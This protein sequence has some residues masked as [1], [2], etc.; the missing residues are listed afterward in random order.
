VTADFVIPL[1]R[2]FFEK[3]K[4]S[5]RKRRLG[6]K[7]LHGQ[8]HDMRVRYFGV[9]L[10][11]NLDDE[12]GYEIAINRFEWRELKMLI[13]ACI[14][15]K[16]DVFIDAGANLGLYSCV[17]GHLGLVPR[18]IAFEPDRENFARLKA[19]LALN[20]L[21]DRVE[22]HEAALG[23]RFGTAM[24]VPSASDN[25]GMSR[26]GAA[27]ADG[28]YEVPVLALDEAVPHIGRRIAIKI[29]VEGYE[30]EVLSGAVQLLGRNGGYAQ[31][32]AHGETAVARLIDRM[33]G[34]G[35]RFR[36]HYGLDARFEKP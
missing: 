2:P 34:L 14:R 6:R 28:S 19:N 31:I 11:V 26:I 33:A 13:A 8:G 5:W 23:A 30:E 32:E 9:N 10:N 3:L 35:W 24:L 27:G 22:V 21:S 36:D 18:V 16:P 20:D 1:R 4:T 17:I 7:P 15:L 25:R 29:D 12:V